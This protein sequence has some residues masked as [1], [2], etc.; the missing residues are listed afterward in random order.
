MTLKARGSKQGSLLS[1][2]YQ[3]FEQ[4]ALL[5][6]I[7]FTPASGELFIGGYEAAN[8][9]VVSE[10][11]SG[12]NRQVTAELRSTFNGVAQ[13][14]RQSFDANEISAIVI[15]AGPGNDTVE[16]STGITS[17]IY[18][19]SGND[20]LVGGS[21]RDVLFGG[22]GNDRLIGNGGDDAAFGFTGND[23][24]DLG[25]GAD[26]VWADSGRNE[27]N[28]G[29]GND[30]VYGGTGVDIV[31]AG[32]GDD[33]VFGL[34]GND[35][36]DGGSG[37]DLLMGLEG[38]D[39]LQSDSGRNLLYG[40]VGDDDI[41]GG[42]G[43]DAL[44]GD[45]GNDTI[46]GNAGN[47]LAYGGAGDD[48]IRGGDGTDWL[49]GQD[50]IDRVFGDA[51]FDLVMGNAGND[52]VDG[53]SQN[54]DVYGNEGNDRLYG[55][56]G[57]DNVFGGA[58]SDLLI[59]G[60]GADQLRGEAGNDE[61]HGGQDS[62]GTILGDNSPDRIDGGSGQDVVRYAAAQSSYD[63]SRKGATGF[64]VDDRRTGRTGSDDTLIGAETLTFAGAALVD[65]AEEIV[66]Q[67]V[68][69]ANNNGGNRATFFGT[70]EQE[71]EIK[72][73]INDIYSQA[74]IRVRWLTPKNWN[75]TTA[76]SGSGSGTR[77]QGDLDTIV[78]QGDQA[79][80]GSSN[81]AI[82]DM[83]FVSRVPGQRVLNDNQVGGFAIIGASGTAVDVGKNLLS[84]EAGRKLIAQVV[85]HEIAHNLGLTHE[86]A[87]RGNLL[88]GL[89][90]DGDFTN[91]TA[92]QIRTLLASRLSMP[93]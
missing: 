32:A 73:W 7:T 8:S 91:L 59:G 66:I 31:D 13:V 57:I 85:S 14:D 10:T 80:K 24:Y 54:D 19:G 16:N 27:I 22:H 63:V 30:I 90:G 1:H 48:T 33:S 47:D 69:V 49:F 6:G 41:R 26:V 79:G 58:G 82:V 74:D 40:G 28:S 11:G 50:G 83:Y 76:N 62:S 18:A 71:A 75:N 53:G 21:A 87:P 72:R 20:V 77:P 60:S 52:L 23:F 68:I 34:A 61:L 51:G 56:A 36:L 92:A 12:S 42:S 4:R 93:L 17:T 39:L 15:V 64:T 86:G 84:F 70:A 88:Y 3:K 38:N 29:N 2:P 37:D 89:G 81:S 43:D 65:V 45:F 78:N 46:S 67:P 35:Q 55:R 9:I 44:V 25:D 5:A